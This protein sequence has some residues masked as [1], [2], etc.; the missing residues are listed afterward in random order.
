MARVGSTAAFEFLVTSDTIGGLDGRLEVWNRALYAISDF[1]F[2]G[3]GIG[4][5]PLVVPQLY[6]FFL[7]TA[8]TVPHAHNQ[9]LQIAV[10]LGLPGFIAFLALILVAGLLLFSIVVKREKHLNWFLAIGGL[11]SLVAVNVHG[12]LDAALWGNKLA[13]LPWLLF[14]VAALLSRKQGCAG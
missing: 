12:I 4:T 10:D 5:F 6:P 1:P 14:A 13:F 11:T 9:W 7:S 3:I 2:T 8:E